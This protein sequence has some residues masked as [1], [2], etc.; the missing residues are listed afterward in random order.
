M[1]HKNTAIGCFNWLIILNTIHLLNG[2][3]T[4]CISSIGVGFGI[5]L[6]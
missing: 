3:K 1:P 6:N 4:R 2:F 5:E